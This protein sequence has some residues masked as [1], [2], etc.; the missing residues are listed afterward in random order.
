MRQL[1]G[2][3]ALALAACSGEPPRPQPKPTEAPAEGI[4]ATVQGRF[5][6]TSAACT[7]DAR[8]VDDLLTITADS[9]AFGLHQESVERI[10]PR[11]GRI[12]FN[13]AAPES[14]RYAFL[15]SPDNRQLR[16][17]A[18]GRPDQIFTRCPDQPGR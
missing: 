15:I 1:I 16:L 17:V 2:M 6:L 12:I 5:A 9:I 14:R 11:P 3:A 4:P 10:T 8:N 13:T 18:F 7:P